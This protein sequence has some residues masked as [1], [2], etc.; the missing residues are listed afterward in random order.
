[1]DFHSKKVDEDTYD[2]DVDSWTTFDGD[3]EDYCYGCE[4]WTDNDGHGNCKDCGIKFDSIDGDW[5]ATAHTTKTSVATAPTISATGDIYLSL[6]H[7]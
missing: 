3:D 4:D 2:I 5:S 7:I 1:M 6:I